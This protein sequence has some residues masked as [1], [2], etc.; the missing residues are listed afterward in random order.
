MRGIVRI[1]V[2]EQVGY[3]EWTERLGDDREWMIQSLQSEVY[4]AAQKEA[5][6]HGGFVLPIRYDI[7]LLLSSGL[8][9]ESHRSVLE[10]VSSL[11][12]VPVR[13]AS[14][15]SERPL[16]AV[17]EAWKALQSGDG[18]FQYSRCGGEEYAVVAH[19]DIN[20]VTHATRLKGPVETYYD[21]VSLISGISRKA[22]D[23]GAIVQYLGGDNILAVLPLLGDVESLTRALLVRGDLK[24]GVGVA[25]KA[26][27]S[28]ALAASALHDIRSGSAG[29]SVVVKTAST[30]LEASPH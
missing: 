22:V 11:S 4:A 13:M 6:K 27:D 14:S 21:V 28:L 16:D 2:I 10:V 15:C 1:G 19:I 12:E 26:R 20:N 18:M 7:M 30:S 3:R 23:K 17:A 29:D 24:A 5:S 9:E 8:D 25:R